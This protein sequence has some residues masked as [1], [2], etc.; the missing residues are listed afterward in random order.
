[1]ARRRLAAAGGV[2]E[3]L[4]SAAERP[5]VERLRRGRPGGDPPW[6]RP[7]VLRVAPRRARRTRA[8]APHRPA[9]RRRRAR[10]RLQLQRR[11]RRRCR[12][13]RR[14]PVDDGSSDALVEES[15]SDD[16]E[17]NGDDAASVQS[18]RSSDDF[19][20]FFSD[21]FV[22][23][24]NSDDAENNGDDAAS[25]QSNRSSDDDFFG[26]SD[27]FVDVEESDDDDDDDVPRK[28]SADYEYEPKGWKEMARA[29]VDRSAG[30]CVAFW[31]RADDKLL[32]Y[33]SDRAPYLKSL[34][35]STHYDVSCQVLTNVI[36]KF[37]MLKELELVL[38]CSFYYVARPSYDF[39]H[40]LQSAMKSCIHLKTFAIRCADKSLASTYYH[41]DES[42]E[43]FTVPKKHG[44]RSLTLFGDTFTKPIILSVLN[45]CPKLRSLDVTNVAYLRMDEEEELRNKCL[46]IKDFRL[47][48][49]P[50][51]VSSSESDDDCIGGCC[52]CC[53]SWY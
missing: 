23:E 18:N 25:V 26:F 5:P 34:R 35:V 36:Q 24:S 44:L 46:K 49:P 14:L 37:P 47:F 43:A 33:L 32:L 28:E 27:A 20:G 6:R 50:P 12:R 41:D 3:G 10:R 8:V 29:A 9:Q 39:A 22:E 16:A 2:V 11:R 52:C 48:S 40:L 13:F 51:K 4:G 19:F 7:R 38:K 21:A 53:D 17:N 42:Q 31:G 45:C 15:D 1:M 30:E